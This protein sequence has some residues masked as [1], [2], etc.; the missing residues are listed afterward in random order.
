MLET[1]VWPMLTR[2]LITTPSTGDEIVVYSMFRISFF[3]AAS[4]CLRE[5]SASS[6]EASATATL[7][8]AVSS[9][10]IYWS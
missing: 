5:A 10:A 9:S 7:A 6:R 1:T 8:R 3:R 4:A 2:R